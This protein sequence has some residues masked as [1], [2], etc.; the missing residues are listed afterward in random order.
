[1]AGEAAIRRDILPNRPFGDDGWIGRTIAGSSS[2]EP[3]KPGRPREEEASLSR[4]CLENRIKGDNS[5]AQG[6]PFSGPEIATTR[7]D[8]R[9]RSQRDR[10]RTLAVQLFVEFVRIFE[11]NRLRWAGGHVDDSRYDPAAVEWRPGRRCNAPRRYGQ[12]GARLR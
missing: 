6:R 2:K 1:L 8:P 12:R 3:G 7:M 11:K 10:L 5:D 9:L 4:G